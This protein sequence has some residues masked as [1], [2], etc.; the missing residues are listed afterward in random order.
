VLLLGACSSEGAGDWLS[1][2]RAARDSWEERDAPASIEQAAAIPYATLGIRLDEGREQ[3]LVL[4]TDDHGERL[5]TSAARVAITTRDGRIVRTAGFGTDLGG[6]Y[7]N[8]EGAEVWN[9]PH[10]YV[11][12]A[13]FPDLGVYSAL[14]EC[15]VTPEGRDPI[16]ILGQQF[17]TFRAEEKCR[18]DR[19]DWT[20]SNSY[21]V[22]RE[23]GR[24]WRS[25]QHIHP[26]GPTLEIEYL[27]PPASP[28]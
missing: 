16:S 2:Y 13:D 26:K 21:W 15:N 27:R 12:T 14:V 24:V 1:L 19:L 7:A 20:F 6:H 10:S 25:I 3:I 18:S 4:A 11:W 17:D 8:V 28:G 23:T 9:T 22:S 5:W